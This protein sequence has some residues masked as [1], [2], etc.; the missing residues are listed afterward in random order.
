MPLWRPLR[1]RRGYY[2]HGLVAV[3]VQGIEHIQQ[4]LG[5]HQGVLV[6]PNHPTHADPYVMLEVGDQLERPFYFMAAWQVFAMTH[7]I[8]RRVL[9]Q[10]GCFSIN[11]EG[12]DL[13]AYRQAVDILRANDHPLVIFPEGEVFHLNDRVTPL[14]ASGARPRAAATEGS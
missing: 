10:H 8:G 12:H 14:R 4:A 5:A 9:R 13:Q 3:Q 2:E 11:R 7:R 1:R 6:T